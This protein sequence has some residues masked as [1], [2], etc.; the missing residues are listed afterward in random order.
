MPQTN[1]SINSVIIGPA[2]K[3][4]FNEL[5]VAQLSGISQIQFPYNVNTSIVNTSLTGSG[6]VTHSTSMARINSGAASSSSATMTSREVV[7]YLSGQGILT[8][9]T[10]IYGSP[11]PGNIQVSGIGDELDGF[12]FGYNGTTFSVLHRNTG[13]DNWIPQ[14]SWNVDKFDGTGISGVTINPHMGNVFKIQFQW[15]GFGSIKFFIENPD[16]GE[17]NLVHSISYSNANIIPSTQ[18]PCFYLFCE[19]KNTSNTTNITTSISSMGAFTEGLVNNIGSKNAESNT[20]TVSMLETNIIT[21]KDNTSYAG[22]VN[23][24]RL[25]FDSLSIMNDS[26]SA[27]VIR[28]RLNPIVAGLPVF[29]DIDPNTSCASYDKVGTLVTEGT[30]FFSFFIAEKSSRDINLDDFNVRLF[31]NEKLVFSGQ[32]MGSNSTLSVGVSWRTDF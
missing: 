24:T 1:N 29:T 25:L 4:A 18:N 14:S 31:P 27:A 17:F 6:S 20:K 28:M 32:S 10:C 11:A 13:V 19:S 30:M 23:R 8:L 7:H 12:F 15:L 2:L 3:S 9:F 21:I 22:K 5:M 26:N 16:T